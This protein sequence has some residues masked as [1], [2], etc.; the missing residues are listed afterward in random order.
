MTVSLRGPKAFNFSA[1]LFFSFSLFLFFARYCLRWFARYRFLASLISPGSLPDIVFDWLGFVP[2][3]FPDIVSWPPQFWPGS[4]P[5][6]VCS[7]RLFCP[8]TWPG[9]W[10]SVWRPEPVGCQGF[11]SF[12]LVPLSGDGGVAG[13]GVRGLLKR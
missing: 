7:W 3:R 1:V 2:D 4:L 12:V 8:G 10:L 13:G 9:T 5:D 6:I 11:S